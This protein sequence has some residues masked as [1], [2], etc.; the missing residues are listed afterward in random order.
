MYKVNSKYDE[1]DL[2]IWVGDLNCKPNSNTI[3]Y[4][5]YGLP[6]SQDN[7]DFAIPDILETS[8]LIYEDLQKEEKKIKWASVYE[9]YGASIKDS[10]RK[11]PVF[12]NY[13]ANFKD[14]LD[15]ILYSKNK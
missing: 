15:H 11:Y 12:T 2:I 13:T 9:R 4:V 8:Q 6:P 14:T 10:T 3:Q 7:I 5:L 1:K